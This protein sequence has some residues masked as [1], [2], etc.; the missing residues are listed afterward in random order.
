MVLGLSFPLNKKI[1]KKKNFILTDNINYGC[2]ALFSP[3]QRNIKKKKIENKIV[4][5]L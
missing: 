4:V 3:L 5:N 2:W 1:F